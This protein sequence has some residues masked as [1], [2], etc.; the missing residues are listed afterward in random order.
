AP[1]RP[2]FSFMSAIATAEC[3]IRGRERWRFRSRGAEAR[4]CGVIPYQQLLE[5]AARQQAC[6]TVAQARSCG[7]TDAQL[8]HRLRNGSLERVG[9]RVLRGARPARPPEQRLV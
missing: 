2:P 1:G 4:T 7:L 5:L 9:S 6:L 3:T 8:R